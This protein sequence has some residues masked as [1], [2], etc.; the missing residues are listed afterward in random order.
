VLRHLVVKHGRRRDRAVADG[1][2]V[3]KKKPRMASVTTT[4]GDSDVRRLIQRCQRSNQHVAFHPSQ[5]V[6]PL[7]RR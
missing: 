1:A 2:R 5:E 6:L 7:H 3:R 4:R